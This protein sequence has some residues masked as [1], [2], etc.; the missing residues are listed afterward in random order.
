MAPAAV[1]AEATAESYQV[2]VNGTQYDVVVSPGTGD[3]S[4]IAPAT[5][6]VVE[7]AAPVSAGTS[8]LA[9]MTGNVIEV[10]VSVGQQVKDGDPV[11]VIEAMKMETEIRSTTTGS[12]Q[13]IKVN[14]GDAIRADQVLM[15]IA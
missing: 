5:S 7:V 10:L 3:I 15:T 1:A 9:P 6:P 2:L 13:S 8:I 4:H 12:V 14:K 11:L